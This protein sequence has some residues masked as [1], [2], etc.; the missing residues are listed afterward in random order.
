MPHLPINWITQ[1]PIDKEHKS[2]ILLGYLQRVKA[3][4]AE[5]K[6]YPFLSHILTHYEA[7]RALRARQEGIKKR[8]SPRLKRADFDHMV[9]T[10]ER[11]CDDGGLMVEIEAILQYSIPR[12]KR[13][14]DTG[15]RNYER[16]ERRLSLTPV[17]FLPTYQRE[18]YLLIRIADLPPIATYKY[19]VSQLYQHKERCFG[20]R[21]ESLGTTT[22]PQFAPLTS[23]K[24]AL[25]RKHSPLD[26]V[27]TFSV[28]SP[29]AYPF[30]ETLLPI[31]QRRLMREVFSPRPTPA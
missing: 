29:K 5:D 1:S 4:F 27:A 2:Y 9:L 11:M 10:Y 3:A 24:H 22:L 20:I 23:L 31:V 13:V 17:G 12:I 18:G 21:L 16:I 19:T 25:I 30:A 28:T 15:C 26:S 8:F 7:L 14:L 6:L